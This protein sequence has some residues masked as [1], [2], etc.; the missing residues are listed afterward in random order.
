MTDQVFALFAHLFQK[1]LTLGFFILQ[2]LKYWAVWIMSHHNTH[3]FLKHLFRRAGECVLA[4]KLFHH[5][6]KLVRIDRAMH[7]TAQRLGLTRLLYFRLDG[8][9]VIRGPRW[10]RWW[11]GSWG[12][13][14][15]TTTAW[16]IA[17]FIWWRGLSR[18][19]CLV[20]RR[21]VPHIVLQTV[22]ST[23]K[24]C[25]Q[26]SQDKLMR[27]DP[28]KYK[29]EIEK[30]TNVSQVYQQGIV[31]PCVKHLFIF[32]QKIDF[33]VFISGLPACRVWP[34]LRKLYKLLLP[35]GKN[36]KNV[37]LVIIDLDRA[38]HEGHVESLTTLR[39]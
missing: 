19:F 38:L 1:M 14:A 12:I 2:V 39:I 13:R 18:Y 32:S 20:V 26:H 21:H 25:M 16:C 6:T 30:A 35:L 31:L 11:A 36:F 17:P 4:M 24:R 9:L 3:T 29:N 15:W 28:A 10:R 27:K 8:L 7:S 33:Q 22:D 34:T 5:H 23:Y 37:V